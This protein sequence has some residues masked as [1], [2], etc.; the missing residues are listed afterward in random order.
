L[1][2]GEIEVIRSTEGTQK[3][4]MVLVLSSGTM[5]DVH[6]AVEREMKTKVLFKVIGERHDNIWIDGVQLE[7]KELLIYIIKYFG[8]KEKARATG[9]EIAMTVDGAKLDNYCIHVICGFKIT[10]KDELNPLEV[11]QKDELKRGKLLLPTIQSSKNA[12][13]TTS[14]IAKDNKSTYKKCLHHMFEFGQELRDVGVPELGWKP[15]RVS[16]PQNTKR[17]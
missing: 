8:L 15:C 13:Q 11:D 6:H 2:L 1:N 10:D 14:I 5:K 7:V 12:F 4:A 16:E 9:C 3:G 17:N